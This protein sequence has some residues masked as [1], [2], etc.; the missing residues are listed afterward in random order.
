MSAT[1]R[2]L[3]QVSSYPFLSPEWIAAAQAIRDEYRDKVPPP[4]IAMR[5]NVVL[6]EVPF[7]DGEIQGFVDTSD[8][9]MILE[10]GAL[11]DPEVTLTTDYATAHALFV[12]Q[13]ASKL[14]E[15]F[16]MGKI[17]I[18]GDVAKILGLTPTLDPNEE[19]L[20]LEIRE[21]LEAIT[22]S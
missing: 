7:G 10:L 1:R 15:S 12:S 19:S 5:A 18:T 17:L 16:M 14:M 20:A 13:D 22:A 3:I 6:R 8:G 21:R 4:T 2:S 9:A 11:E